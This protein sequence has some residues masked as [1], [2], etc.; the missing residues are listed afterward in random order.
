MTCE[1]V[2]RVHDET[3]AKLSDIMDA[4]E[5]ALDNASSGRKKS[6]YILPQPGNQIAN[7]LDSVK[8]VSSSSRFTSKP[9]AERCFVRILEKYL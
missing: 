2:T 1:P 5:L 4:G 3:C 7:L 9:S 6:A 8:G